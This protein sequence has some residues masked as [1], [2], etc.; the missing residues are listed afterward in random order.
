MALLPLQSIAYAAQNQPKK[1][2][3]EQLRTENSKTYLQPDGKTYVMEQY[4]KPIHFKKNGKWENINSNV[5]EVA[6]TKAIDSELPLS[7]TANQFQVGFAKNSK[8]NKLVRFKL[9]QAHVDFGLLT[10]SATV[11]VKKEANKVTYPSVYPYTDLVYHVD[12]DGV[13]EEWILQKYNGQHVFS[14]TLNTKNVEPKL[15]KDGSVSFVD[16]KGKVKFAIPRPIMFDSQDSSSNEVKFSI[17]KEGNKTILDLTADEKWLTDPKRTYPVSIDP[18]LVVQGGTDTFDSFVGSTS[19]TTNY[20]L[21]P[22]LITGTHPTYGTNRSFVKFNLSPLLPGANITYA[23]VTLSQYLTTTNSETVDVYPITS[24]WTSGGVTWNNQP[25]LGSKQSSTS[26]AGAGDYDFVITSVARGWYGGSLQNHGIAL[27]MATETN[28]RKSY[29]SSDY[30]TDPT[31]KPKLTITYMVEPNGQEQFWTT[32]G[33][34]VNTYNGNFF[35]P[36]TDVSISGR[37]PEETIDRYYNSR[38]TSS[39]IFGYGWTS[40]IEQKLIDSGLGPILYIDADG[41]GHSFTPNGDGTY[42]SLKYLQYELKKNADN[43][44]ILTD[45]EQTQYFF[46]T[47]GRLTKIT[48][49]N[50]NSLTVTYTGSLPTELTDAS[51]RK[52]TLTYDANNRVTK[53]TDPANRTANYT[54]D[55]AGDLR[56]VVKKDA[57]DVTLTTVSYAYDASHNMTTITDANGNAKTVVYNTDDRVESISYPITVNGTVQ[58]ATIS[59]LYNTVTGLTTVTDPKG[60]KTLYTHNQYGNVEQVT[61]DPTG[62]NYKQTFVYDADQQLTSQKDANTNAV[63]GT[64]TYNYTYDSNGNLIKTTNPLNETTET[65]Y[66][67][68]NNAIQEK[69]ANGNVT[70]NEYDDSNNQISTTDSAEK[71]SAT[72]YD[73]YGNVTEQ[74]TMISPG[75]NLV[76]NGSFEIDRD[77]DNWPDDWSK[78][79]TATFTWNNTAL[80]TDGILLGAKSVKISN[81]STTTA[82]KS[83]KIPYD[84]NKTYVFSGSV[85]TN[86]AVGHARVYVFGFKSDG[87]YKAI[88]S[89]VLTGT[90]PATRLQIVVNPGDMPVGT[91]ELE[92]RPYTGSGTG[93]YIFDGIQVEEEF[94]G[95]YNVV[96]NSDYER[97]ADPVDNIPDR[98]K[99]VGE[100]AAGDGLDSTEKHNGAK[101]VKLV[102]NSTL[103][104]TIYQDIPIQG[105][106][107]SVLTVSGFS[108]TQNPTPGKV[109]GYIINLYDSSVGS[110]PGGTPVQKFT[111][112]FDASK[113]HDWQHITS[114][115]KTNVKFDTIRVYYE[116]SLQTG[117]AWFDT[118]KVLLGSVTTKN[119]YDTNGN[120]QTKTTDPQGRITQNAYD[121]V[122]NVTSETVG[123]DTTGFTY[124]G[125]DRLTKVTDANAQQTQYEYDGNGN[126]TKIINAKNKVTTNEYNQL[127]QVKKTTDAN[128]K[129][130]TSDY[131]LNGNQTKLT[132]ANGNTVEF[133]Y[134]SV[135][136]QTSISFNGSQEYAFVYD[137]NGN[138]TKET[139]GS[140][141]N[142]NYTYDQNNKLK[143]IGTDDGET[144]TEF[145]YDKNGN[146]TQQKFTALTNVFT[147][148]YAYDSQNQLK[149]ITENGASRGTFTYNE[150]D[151]LAAR[152]TGDNTITLNNYNGAGD[153]ISQTILDKNGSVVEKYTYGY[154]TE[155]RIDSV[156]S[157]AGTTSYAYD[158][159][160]QLTKETRP[161]GTIY[162][163]TY[164]TVGNRL[165][166][167]VT[168]DGTTTTTTY[169]YDDADQLTAVNATTFSYDN[170]GNLL[171][172]GQKTYT[173]DALNRLKTVKDSS[174]NTIATLSYRADGM[175]TSMTM[176]TGG[177]DY[178]YDKNKNVIAETKGLPGG[179]I[180]VLATYTY[181]SDNLPVSMNRGGTT[182]Y[183]Q[184]NAHG[185][186]TKLTD[187]NGAVVATYEYDAYGNIISETGTVENPYRYAGY[188]YDKVTGLYY[189]KARYYDSK[190]GRFL[191]RDTYQGSAVAPLSLNKYSYV[192]N[193]PVNYADYTGNY[194]DYIISKNLKLRSTIVWKVYLSNLELGVLGGT[195]TYSRGY[196]AYWANKSAKK[197]LKRLHKYLWIPLAFLWAVNVLRGSK[198]L[199]IIIYRHTLLRRSTKF[200]LWKWQWE[201]RWESL[202][203]YYDE[204]ILGGRR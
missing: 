94:Y 156:T 134:N 56:T 43:T 155:G 101:S 6:S 184:L 121:T 141:D 124:D 178:H 122:G 163:Y 77:S 140:V 201:T 162:E 107:G 92:I 176:S 133:G 173:Y 41:T 188:R 105:A 164:D 172:D 168:K 18:S 50:N 179:G 191:T 144:L 53:V 33:S 27:K 12:Q 11:Q 24:T 192:E 4:Q 95:A 136:R 145:S 202:Y 132:Q 55:A 44:Y 193:D 147:N 113:S 111:F 89:N 151:L 170:S 158:K 185:D 80:A 51:G 116:Y 190:N 78:V 34:D 181:N 194:K 159:L 83:A 196:E 84:P 157:N 1:V 49:S 72:K 36:E 87:T 60:T 31:K 169:S 68:N 154:D 187:G 64:A 110:I 67:S 69:D 32:A 54:Y 22:F 149:S 102:G 106:A 30:A 153:L 183:Y 73:S 65:T 3:L 182:Y 90:Q 197:K 16:S 52:T 19:P 37:G 45:A 71:S 103:Y 131:D 10:D 180:Q 108:K 5:Q 165:S 167:K 23:K 152:K 57:S 39:G 62:L 97:D 13:K 204:A 46:N 29:R 2:E 114:E 198:G 81:P 17:R 88:S 125:L 174:G 58:T 130:V 175:R 189:L 150:A 126:V 171:S 200:N 66:D 143:S 119:T 118:A 135:N 76:I 146:M 98:W 127:N 7:N 195:Y 104:K 86:N 28:D 138:M 129:S 74:T 14:M 99:L 166:M 117:M 203:S 26:V 63:N 42:Q 142:T 161:D 21:E 137:A 59:F 20:G 35:L 40:M 128:G 8:T 100:L 70:S 93:E 38:T 109:Y 75:N 15:Q 112:N 120:Y 199:T 96:E 48:D 79:G 177:I 91:T 148:G 85:A 25:T 123:T 47:S 82:V 139:K 186:V 115:I 61:Q 9:D 160:D